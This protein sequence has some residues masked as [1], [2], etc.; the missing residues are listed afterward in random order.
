MYSP[1]GAIYQSY[2][3]EVATTVVENNKK[4]LQFNALACWAAFGIFTLG[5]VLPWYQEN[6]VVYLYMV[7]FGG[8]VSDC[9]GYWESG[10]Q[11][12]CSEV[13][14]NTVASVIVSII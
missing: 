4:A 12:L 3:A 11:S 14:L 9:V 6:A 8:Y 13:K 7:C 1:Y 5:L 10:C 2:K